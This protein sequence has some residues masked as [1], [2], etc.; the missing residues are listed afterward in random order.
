MVMNNQNNHPNGSQYKN[1]VRYKSENK[2]RY[3]VN[4]KIR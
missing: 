1:I 4:I 3:R 2:K